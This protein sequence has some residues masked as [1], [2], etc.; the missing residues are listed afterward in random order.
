MKEDFVELRQGFVIWNR[1]RSRND[2][3]VGVMERWS[4]VLSDGSS[5]E[6]FGASGNPLFMASRI[7]P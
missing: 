6:G 7:E 3:S 2:G 4:D 1:G 5:W